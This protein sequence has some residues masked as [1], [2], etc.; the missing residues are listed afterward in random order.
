MAPVIIDFD[1]RDKCGG[2]RVLFSTSGGRKL[3][4]SAEID[5]LEAKARANPPL[6]A[7]AEW[8]FGADRD[9]VLKFL[10]KCSQIPPLRTETF[11]RWHEPMFHLFDR[12][13]RQNP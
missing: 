1:I 7:P 3:N 11:V 12:L 9:L 8:H 6:H 4:F 13:R 10:P 5:G 2:V